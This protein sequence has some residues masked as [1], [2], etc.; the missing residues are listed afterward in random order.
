MR[1]LTILGLFGN[2]PCKAH[3]RM[4]DETEPENDLI[5]PAAYNENSTKDKVAG[6]EEDV[7]KYLARNTVDEWERFRLITVVNLLRARV[8]KP[9]AAEPL[10]PPLPQPAHPPNLPSWASWKPNPI[11]HPQPRAVAPARSPFPK[12]DPLAV[13]PSWASW[14][15]NPVYH[16]QPRAAA[17][18]PPPDRFELSTPP[19]PQAS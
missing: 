18:T 2:P 3:F 19:P 9:K 12:P 1:R 15:P 11:Y 10:L 7:T 17:S 13:L 5:S 4:T 6:D 14:K 16:P 8:T